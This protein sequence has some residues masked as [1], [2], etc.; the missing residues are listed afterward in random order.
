MLR[1]E[2]TVRARKGSST[3]S[4]CPSPRRRCLRRAALLE[5]FARP[6]RRTD[7]A[8][9]AVYTRQ[10]SEP[11]DHAR[12]PQLSHGPP[13]ATSGARGRDGTGHRMTASRGRCRFSRG[14]VHRSLTWHRGRESAAS[15]DKTPTW[16]SEIAPGDRSNG[17]KTSGTS[18]SNVRISLPKPFSALLECLAHCSFPAQYCSARWLRG[19][20]TT[21]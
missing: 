1:L 8:Q 12:L 3:S 16:K 18:G 20:S 14:N 2:A 11:S 21:G 4:S 15:A 19:S 13:R 10:P 17:E 6:E 5:V 9:K 7:R